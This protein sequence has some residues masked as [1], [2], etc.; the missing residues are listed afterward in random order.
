MYE[1]KQKMFLTANYIVGFLYLWAFGFGIHYICI[2]IVS[3]ICST[4]EVM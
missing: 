2:F 3:S 4:F 1:T